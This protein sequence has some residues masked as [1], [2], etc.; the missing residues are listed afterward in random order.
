MEPNK[1]FITLINGLNLKNYLNALWPN[2]MSV[3]FP[4]T[5]YC[6]TQH[7]TLFGHKY[8]FGK[9]NRASNKMASFLSIGAVQFGIYIFNGFLTCRSSN[10][11][12]RRKIIKTHNLFIG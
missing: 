5:V 6:I 4:N 12:T 1:V 7:S 10:K 2:K 8:R 11:V 3:H 9:K